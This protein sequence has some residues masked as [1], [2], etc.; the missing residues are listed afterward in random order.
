LNP[1]LI[2]TL[3]R[4][5]TCQSVSCIYV[6]VNCSLVDLAVKPQQ[7]SLTYFHF[8]FHIFVKTYTVYSIHYSKLALERC[9]VGNKGCSVGEKYF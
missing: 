9:M 6:S 3:L 1:D 2:V 8:Q 5:Y 7:V 4:S